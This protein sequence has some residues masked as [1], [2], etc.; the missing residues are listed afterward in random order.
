VPLSV[1]ILLVL[2]A[3]AIATVAVT[4][5]L[6]LRWTRYRRYFQLV[7]WCKPRRLRLIRRRAD[8]PALPPPLDRLAGKP[9]FRVRWMMHGV[10]GGVML[11]RADL[12]DRTVNFLS[13]SVAA[14]GPLAALRPSMHAHALADELGL[15]TYPSTRGVERFTLHGEEPARARRL[16][17]SQ[18]AGLLPRDIGLIVGR[19]QLVL[20]FSSRPFDQLEFDRMMGL[21][22][23]LVA[24]GGVV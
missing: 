3:I 11:V 19:G 1:P 6:S 10:E 21:A 20:D 8:V 4:L 17:E 13:R 14:D 16:N 24:T 23:Q 12:A 7:E 9:N 18:A 15:F 2:L 22:D 5:V